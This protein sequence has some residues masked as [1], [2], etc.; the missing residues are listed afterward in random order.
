M[1]LPIIIIIFVIFLVL[2]L[3]RTNINLII[4]GI[5]YPTGLGQSLRTYI[6]L[7]ILLYLDFLLK[8]HR[9]SPRW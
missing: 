5:R 3:K 6:F 9:L 2:Y 4:Y 7:V 1:Y 8:E